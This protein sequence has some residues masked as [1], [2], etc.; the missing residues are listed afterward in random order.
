MERRRVR[1]TSVLPHGRGRAAAAWRLDGP[2]AAAPREAG[3]APLLRPTLRVGLD[4]L[5]RR[6]TGVPRSASGGA[7]LNTS[8]RVGASVLMF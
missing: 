5:R 3:L 4:P 1:E 7:A 8:L 6:E 2:E